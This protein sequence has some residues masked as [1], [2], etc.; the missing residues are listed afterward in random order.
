MINTPPSR[1]DDNWLYN[2][3]RQVNIL[4]LRQ[5]IYYLL[6]LTLLKNYYLDFDIGFSRIFK[7]KNNIQFNF[8]RWRHDLWF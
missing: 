3:T 5:K 2:I 8:L 6:E 4:Q 7:K 1:C